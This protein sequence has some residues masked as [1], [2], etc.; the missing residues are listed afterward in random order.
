MGPDDETAAV[1]VVTD[2]MNGNY[3]LTLGVGDGTF[4]R[5]KL[6]EKLARKI[7]RELNERLD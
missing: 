1:A 4:K 7:R 6:T 3:F 2:D 5:W